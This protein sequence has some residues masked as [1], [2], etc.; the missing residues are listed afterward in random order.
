MQIWF[1]RRHAEPIAFRKDLKGNN[2]T[3][4]AL[5][6]KNALFLTI[7]AMHSHEQLSEVR[8]WLPQNRGYA[9]DTG[10]QLMRLIQAADL[11]IV[12]VDVSTDVE[13]LPIGP[14]LDL[15]KTA[16]GAWANAQLRDV[17]RIRWIHAIEK[18]SVR[19]PETFESEGTKTLINRL[20]GILQ[21]LRNGGLYIVDELDRS[22]HPGRCAHLLEL[23]TDTKTNPRNAQILFTTRRRGSAA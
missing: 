23:F 3:I 15:G 5:T 7:A 6:R 22:L 12:G 14:S 21:V 13:T 9:S 8:T 19:F 11:G 16:F 1:H 17:K 20:P 10:S 18:E 4:E 2:R